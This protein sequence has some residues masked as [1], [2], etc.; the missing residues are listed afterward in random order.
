MKIY[1]FCDKEYIDMKNVFVSSMKDPFEHKFKL[2]EKINIDKTKPGSGIDIWTYKTKMAIDAIRENLEKNEIII[3]SDIDIQFFKPC[4]S[5]VNES[6]KNKDIVFQKEHEK[7][8]INI[9][10]IGI[11]CNMDTL[12]FWKVVYANILL[13]N[14]WDQAI[15]N[16]MIYKEKYN[17]KWGLFPRTIWNWSQGT[18]QNDIILHHA[19][20][21]ILKEKKLE[22]MEYVKSVV[23]KK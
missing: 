7:N 3:I 14:D 4:I 2:L 17:I 20:C 16:D 6:L 19:N 12:N 13:T 15:I 23:N 1:Y 11:R 5:T 18:L 9:G 22:Q 10:F 21:R 8:G